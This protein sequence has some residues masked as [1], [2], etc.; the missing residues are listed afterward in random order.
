MGG[1]TLAEWSIVPHHTLLRVS[2]AH[3]TTGIH[4]ALLA[5]DVD[6][7]HSALG[8]ISLVGAGLLSGT[9]SSQ[10]QRVARISILTDAGAVM[11]VSDTARVGTT[12]NVATGVNTPVLAL[13]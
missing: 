7:A 1:L 10:V 9:S 2:A 12:L 11:V 8:T 13:D 5:T 4:T 3:H 6:A